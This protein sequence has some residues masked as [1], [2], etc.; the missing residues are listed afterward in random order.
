MEKVLESE[1]EESCAPPEG[2]VFANIDPETGMSV[3]KK[4]PNS[5]V[6]CFVEGTEPFEENEK[7]DY[8]ESNKRGSRKLDLD[9]F[10]KS[11][12]QEFAN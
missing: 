7:E 5:V 1:P 10:M 3:K 2:I 8:A 4:L 12:R 6:Q 9:S 11:E